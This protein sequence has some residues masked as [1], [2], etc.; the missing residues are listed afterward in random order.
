MFVADLDREKTLLY[1][2]GGDKAGGN[3]PVRAEWSLQAVS[4]ACGD[5]L[6]ARAV[7][8]HSWRAISLSKAYG[9]WWKP[10]GDHVKLLDS[11]PNQAEGMG[12]CLVST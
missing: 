7:Q 1:F 6:R 10:Q 4:N 2:R 9:F 3:L 12:F 5:L 11:T 8:A